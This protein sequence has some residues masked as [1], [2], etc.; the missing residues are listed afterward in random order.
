MHFVLDI[1][2]ALG[3]TILMKRTTI[4]LTG[5]QVAALAKISKKT[6]IKQSELIRRFIDAGLRKENR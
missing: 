6:G 4:W 1:R 5:F 2:M 3:H